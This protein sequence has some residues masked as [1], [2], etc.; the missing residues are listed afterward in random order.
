MMAVRDGASDFEA[1]QAAGLT[2]DEL[3]FVFS[4]AEK[5]HEGYR[6]FRDQYFRARHRVVLDVKAAQLERAKDPERGIAD[7]RYML[8][9]IDPDQYPEKVVEKAAAAPTMIV[10]GNTTFDVRTKFAPGGPDQDDVVDAEV[11]E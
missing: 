2:L 5:G 9:T 11:V 4:L 3:E 10:S 8:A 7:R 6:R 1:A